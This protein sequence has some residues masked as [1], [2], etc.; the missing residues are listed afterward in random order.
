MRVIPY[1]C[2]R[3]GEV[4]ERVKP[5]WEL[6]C[7]YIARMHTYYE[8]VSTYSY[9]CHDASDHDSDTN[10]WIPPRICLDFCAVSRQKLHPYHMRIIE[11]C[12][13][14]LY[15]LFGSRLLH[16]STQIVSTRLS[17]SVQYSLRITFGNC[18]LHLP[19]PTFN[20]TLV[21]SVRGDTIPVNIR[22][23]KAR[24]WQPLF[25]TGDLE[26]VIYNCQPN[27]LTVS[28]FQLP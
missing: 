5:Q 26:Q 14:D 8:V 3:F 19:T 7:P 21:S 9:R 16:I 20:P 2:W 25:F 13:K 22:L 15:S 12:P 10:M 24:R 11:L 1:Q 6:S 23:S 27:G 18:A 28:H 17:Y 4:P